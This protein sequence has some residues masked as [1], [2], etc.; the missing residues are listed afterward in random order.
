MEFLVGLY[1]FYTFISFYFLA[2]YVLTYVQNRKQIFEV[3]KPNEIKSLSIVVPCY[4]AGDLIGKT[5]G[6]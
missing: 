2:L 5:I 3:I 4:N 6:S 1:F